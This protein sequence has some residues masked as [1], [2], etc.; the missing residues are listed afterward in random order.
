MTSIFLVTNAI[1]SSYCIG[2]LIDAGL[3]TNLYSY[4]LIV[5]RAMGK[6]GRFGIDVMVSLT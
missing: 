3:A 5:E 4:S 2:K 6:R 1:I